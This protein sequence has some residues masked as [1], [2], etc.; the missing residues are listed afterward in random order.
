[1]LMEDEDALGDIDGDDEEDGGDAAESSVADLW[2]RLSG[3]EEEEDFIAVVVK[4]SS[5]VYCRRR[6]FSVANTTFEDAYLMVVV[7]V[8][9]AA[10]SLDLG[11]TGYTSKQPLRRY[12]E[13]EASGGRACI[14]RWCIPNDIGCVMLRYR[15]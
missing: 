13:V 9:V 5:D 6:S 8:H 15:E 2:W 4:W 10:A 14:E 7:V 3:E 11:R 1:M 12:P